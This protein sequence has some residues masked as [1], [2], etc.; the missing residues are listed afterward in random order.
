[1]YQK[2]ACKA[3][4]NKGTTNLRIKLPPEKKIKLQKKC[5]SLNSDLVNKQNFSLDLAKMLRFMA[6][7]NY[8]GYL[9]LIGRFDLVFKLFHK[10][11]FASRRLALFK[12]FK[13]KKLKNKGRRLCRTEMFIKNKLTHLPYIKAA[14]NSVHYEQNT[15]KMTPSII[16]SPPF[17]TSQ[18][19]Q[20]SFRQSYY[21][22]NNHHTFFNEKKMLPTKRASNANSFEHEARSVKNH[23]ANL[24]SLSQKDASNEANFGEDLTLKS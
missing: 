15:R 18:G 8:I 23:A 6:K 2:R 5:S 9:I 16:T 3:Y 13:R 14:A 19:P 10:K 4:L 21:Q 20:G 11:K 7:H 12:R 22:I 24:D 1:M 17:M